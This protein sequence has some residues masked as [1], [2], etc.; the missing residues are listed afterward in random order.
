MRGETSREDQK[1][2]GRKKV[3]RPALIKFEGKRV[4]TWD[5]GIKI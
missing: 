3:K 1:G 5:Q 4:Q 2:L